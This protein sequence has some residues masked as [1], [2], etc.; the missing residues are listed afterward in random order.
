MLTNVCILFKLGFC[1]DI[2]KL[3]EQ[4]KLIS[5]ESNTNIFKLFQ[6]MLKPV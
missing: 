3:S 1:F 4:N 6:S 5:F 2:S